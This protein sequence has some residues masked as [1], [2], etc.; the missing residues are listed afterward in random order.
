MPET[1]LYLG[2]GSIF[3]PCSPMTSALTEFLE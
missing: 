3:S 1:E 2:S